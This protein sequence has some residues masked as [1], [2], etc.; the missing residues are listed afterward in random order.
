MKTKEI[1][2]FFAGFSANQMLTHGAFALSGVQFTLFGIAYDRGLNSAGAL[3]WSIAL[4]LLAF[5]AW[6]RK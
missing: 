2:K 5:Y 1:A 4:V 3:V 6:G